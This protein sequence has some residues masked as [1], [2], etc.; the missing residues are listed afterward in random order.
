MIDTP[1][2]SPVRQST[3][4]H[5]DL[6]CRWID[7]DGS[8]LAYKARSGRSPTVVFLPGFKS[9]MEGD[10]AVFLDQ[11]ARAHGQAML[12]LDYAGHG[13]SDGAF[14][15]GTIGSWTEDALAVI[16]K[17]TEGP[18]ILVGS[19]MGGWIM[20]LIALA[21]SNRIAGLVGLAAAPDFTQDLIWPSL[22]DI[23][24]DAI[25]TVGHIDLPTDYGDEPTRITRALIEDGRN[26]LLLTGPIDLTMPVHLIH[27][28][29]DPDVPWSFSTRLAE[30]ITGDNVTVTLVKSG[31]H[32]LS[33][34]QDLALI[35]R[36]VRRLCDELQAASQ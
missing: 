35:S 27:G 19:S 17:T 30:H 33:R 20:L 29:A 4:T 9:D 22:N 6:D 36:S 32:R 16:D 31:D 7:Q 2:P 26:H 24:R 23:Q 34:P 1:I 11:W 15:D 5:R 10:K 25:K 21:R 3:Q 18:L 13:C 12:R 14:A 28:M 8:R